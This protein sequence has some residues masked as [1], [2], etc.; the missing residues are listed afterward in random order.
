MNRTDVDYEMAMLRHREDLA[1]AERYCLAK[2]AAAA[3]PGEPLTEEL[4]FLSLARMLAF[5]GNRLLA[6]SCRLQT[7]TLALA[8]GQ[9]NPKPCA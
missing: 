3:R 4:V 7:Y 6:W 1:V 9:R 5:F 2:Q 8:E